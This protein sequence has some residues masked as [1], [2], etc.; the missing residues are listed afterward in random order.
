[1][2][3]GTPQTPTAYSSKAAK[4]DNVK[5]PENAAA[6]A[7]PAVTT[8]TSVNPCPRPR[9]IGISCISFPP[10]DREALPGFR[11]CEGLT[12][13]ELVSMRVCGHRV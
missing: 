6:D 8:A 10:W 11:A 13:S 4:E 9:C 3:S 1:M 2:T 7:A 12:R 5:D